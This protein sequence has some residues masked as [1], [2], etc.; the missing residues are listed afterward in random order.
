MP[1]LVTYAQH[2]AGVAGKVVDEA[3]TE[4][5]RAIWNAVKTRFA[6]DSQAD[7]ALAR[8]AEEPDNPR[9]QAA[10][11]DHLDEQIQRDPAFGAQLAQLVGQVERTTMISDAVIRE[12]WRCGDGW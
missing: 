1:F 9:R 10:V 5:L 7:G 2:L 3:L 8:L 11:E 6:D 12:Q 4:R